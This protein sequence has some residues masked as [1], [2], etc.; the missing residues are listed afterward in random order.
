MKKCKKVYRY[1]S[2]TGVLYINVL[3]F[4]LSLLHVVFI[5]FLVIGDTS[6]CLVFIFTPMLYDVIGIVTL[7]FS[8]VLSILTL[9]IR[10]DRK[11]MDKNF[12]NLNSTLNDIKMILLEIRNELR[13]K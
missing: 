3:S 8:F 12:I 2:S 9:L 7:I 6:L 5:T 13:R 11:Y 10:V 4:E 1:R